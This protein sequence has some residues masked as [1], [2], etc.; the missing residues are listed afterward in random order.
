MEFT[1]VV[2]AAAGWYLLGQHPPKGKDA[3]AQQRARGGRGEF[4]AAYLVLSL[5]LTSAAFLGWWDTQVLY[6]QQIICSSFESPSTHAT[7]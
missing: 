2:P 6:G 3:Q 5:F 7:K 4:R 1:L